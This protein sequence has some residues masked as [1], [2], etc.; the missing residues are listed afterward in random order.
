MSD[1]HILDTSNEA[2]TLAALDEACLFRGRLIPMPA[3]FYRQW[4]REALSLWCVRRGFYCLPTTELIDLLSSMLG[5]ERAIEIGSGNGVIGRA[6]AIP[7]TDSKM[8]E[9]PEIREHYESLHQEVVNYGDDVEQL[10]ALQAIERY[11]P[12]TVIAAWVTHRFDRRSPKRKGN[13]FGVDEG[14]LLDKACVERYVFIGNERVHA[15]KPILSR[16]H[17]ALRPPYLFSR[18]LDPRNVIWIWER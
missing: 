6:L 8:Q 16:P 12:S 3:S 9:R 14:K 11:Q 10:T 7:R 5:D 4:T 1:H 17:R 13:I 15:A 2:E 18:S